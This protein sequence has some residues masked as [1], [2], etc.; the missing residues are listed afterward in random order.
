MQ[1]NVL[2]RSSGSRVRPWGTREGSACSQVTDSSHTRRH[3]CSRLVVA[4]LKLCPRCSTQ[5]LLDCKTVLLGTSFSSIADLCLI[6]SV[7]AALDLAGCNLSKVRD[8]RHVFATAHTVSI[9]DKSNPISKTKALTTPHPTE[10]PRTP[11]ASTLSSH[12][13]TAQPPD[14][15]GAPSRTHTTPQTSP[16]IAT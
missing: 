9:A 1:A 16:C 12:D 15:T 13:S 2:P 10:S 5:S 3:I 7:S 4:M 6:V 14:H 11:Q 8:R